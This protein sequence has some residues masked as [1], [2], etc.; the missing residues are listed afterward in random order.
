LR[1][2]CVVCSR[3]ADTIYTAQEAMQPC[4]PANYPPCWPVAIFISGS[5]LSYR[6]YLVF[7]NLSDTNEALQQYIRTGGMPHLINLRSYER[8]YFD[9]L[10]NVFDS[11]VLR[12]IESWFGLINVRLLQDLIVY[13]ADNVGSLVTAKRISDFLKS[14]NIRIQTKTILEYLYYLETVFCIDRVKRT[15]VSG[16]KIFQIGDKFYF[17]D[18]GIW[19]SQIPF[20]LKDIGKVPENLVY[21]H[22]KVLRYTIFV[23]KLS[24]KEI[25][26][27]CVKDGKTI[28]LCTGSLP[29]S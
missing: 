28:Y 4:F 7:N 3:V 21:H 14:Q 2:H 16:S 19:H 25:D 9:Y 13:L 11:I 15:E 23:G 8:T 18:L 20:Q 12:D 26:F 1:R 6:E 17:E 29:D 27:V 24:D 10:G 5:S 22:L